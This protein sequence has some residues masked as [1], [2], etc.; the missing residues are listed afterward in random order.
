MGPKKSNN[1]SLTVEKALNILDKLAE[2]GVPT[3]ISELSSYLDVSKSTT[4]RILQ[5]LLKRG[6][7]IQDPETSKY[8]LGYKILDIGNGMLKGIELR[9]IA[10]P[11][12]EGLA[13]ETSF[14]VGLAV[15]NNW[16]MVYLDQV[17]GGGVIR[18]E[19]RVGSRWPM[20]CTAAG[21]A[22]LAFRSGAE[23]DQFLSNGDLKSYTENTIVHVQKLK[24]ELKRIQ[25]QG[26]SF[27]NAEYE[28]DVKAIGSPIFGVQK[29]LIGSVV[30][31]GPAEKVS[32]RSVPALGKKVRKTALSISKAMGFSEE[33][34]LT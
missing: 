21:K 3:R 29:Q 15:M 7:V 14:T 6:Y 8:R 13:R 20:H 12:L 18:L 31:A 2:T 19:L 24:E 5:T 4:Y 9:T 11:H 27:N 22:Y 17:H 34:K 33:P 28:G 1:F 16:Q 10:R 30:M 26:Y 23:I 32:K 25:S